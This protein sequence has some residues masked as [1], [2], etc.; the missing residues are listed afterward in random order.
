[1]AL[2]EEQR[3]RRDIL[4]SQDYADFLVAYG[5]NV[6]VAVEK[7]Q[8]DSYE[9][10][11]SGFMVIHKALS[12]EGIEMLDDYPY[13]LIPEVMGL[14]DTTSMEQSYWCH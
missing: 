14:L 7:Y 5:G 3:E 4:L 9:I 13:N 1:M 11:N 10:I 8:P 2:T 12:L 6:E